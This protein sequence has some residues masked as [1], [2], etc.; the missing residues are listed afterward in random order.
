[1]PLE[2]TFIYLK[3][4]LITM[5]ELFFPLENFTFLLI[6]NICFFLFIVKNNK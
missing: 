4:R 3:A 5:S 1:M 6:Y 2:K